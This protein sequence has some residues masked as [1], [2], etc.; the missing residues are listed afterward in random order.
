MYTLLGL[1]VDAIIVVVFVATIFAY[2]KRGFVASLL[3]IMGTIASLLLGIIVSNLLSPIIFEKFFKPAILENTENAIQ[4]YGSASVED[5]M[6]GVLGVF[7][8]AFVNNVTGAFSGAI[9]S[10]AAGAAEGFVDGVAAPMFVPVISIVIFLIVFIVCKLIAIL[11]EKTFG[12]TVNRIPIVG[13]LNKGLGGALG[14]LG[15]IVNCVLVIFLFWF[16]LAIT[17][18]NLPSFSN[19]DLNG[20]FFYRLFLEYN[21]FF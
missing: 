9:N 12:K 7:P 2:I 5:V 20:S 19:A 10:Q 17:G 3:N 15:G 16:A 14:V 13:G 18:G 21:P 8:D 6:S 4:N 11:L 1:I